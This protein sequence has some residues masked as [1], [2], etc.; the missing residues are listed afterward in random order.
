MNNMFL[1]KNNMHLLKSIYLE[2]IKHHICEISNDSLL[3]QM[4]DILKGFDAY[5]KQLLLT[6]NNMLAFAINDNM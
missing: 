1:P 3:Y 5:N 6:F 2:K 4:N